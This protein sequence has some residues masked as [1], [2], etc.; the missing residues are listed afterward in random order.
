M[1]TLGYPLILTVDKEDGGFVVTLPDFPEVVTQGEGVTEALAQG[2]DLLDEAVANRIA[3]QLDLPV[4]SPTPAGGYVVAV[5]ET[6]CDWG[7]GCWC[8]AGSRVGFRAAG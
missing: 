1:L 8:D 2:E 5:G 7:R 6:G 3:I 4:A